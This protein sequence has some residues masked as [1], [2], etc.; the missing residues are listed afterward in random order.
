MRHGEGETSN[1]EGQRERTVEGSK[2]KSLILRVLLDDL[3]GG[4]RRHFRSQRGASVL[5]LCRRVRWL[6]HLGGGREKNV[7]WYMYM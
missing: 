3:T 2:S 1:D 7:T 4:Y 5:D 6:A